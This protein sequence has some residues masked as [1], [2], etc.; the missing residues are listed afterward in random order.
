MTTNET[1]QG[2]S[3][4]TGHELL[5]HHV[6][7]T[8]VKE[9]WR[10]LRQNGKIIVTVPDN[11]LGPISCI[12]HIRR[13]NKESIS[14]VLSNHFQIQKRRSFKNESHNSPTLMAVGIKAS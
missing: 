9:I 1:P 7:N 2:Q 14:K 13:Y 3:I 11:C 6:Y 8:I 10:I 5:N 4:P 12:K